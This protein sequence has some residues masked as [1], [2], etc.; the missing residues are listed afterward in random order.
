MELGHNRQTSTKIMGVAMNSMRKAAR[1]LAEHK[2]KLLGLL[3]AAA[4]PSAHSV[5]WNIDNYDDRDP[6]A[7]VDISWD[8][9][10]YQEKRYLR[11]YVAQNHPNTQAGVFAKA[12]VTADQDERKRLYQQCVERYPLH[13]KCVANGGNA[14]QRLHFIKNAKPGKHHY[15]VSNYLSDVSK[16]MSLPEKL[17]LV[18]KFEAKYGAQPATHY[19]RAEQYADENQHNKAGAE[20]NKSLSY[21]QS[22]FFHY[23]KAAN[24]K[25]K[26]LSGNGLREKAQ[27]LKSVIG[28]YANNKGLDAQVY[29][30]YGDKLESISGK[31]S[32]STD[33][34]L[35][36]WQLKPSAELAERLIRSSMDKSGAYTA[37]FKQMQELQQKIP[38]LSSEMVT[39]YANKRQPQKAKQAA[40]MAMANCVNG[41]DCQSVVGTILWANQNFINDNNWQA[42]IVNQLQRDY[43]NLNA[44]WKRKYEHERYL[45]R[46]QQAKQALQTYYKGLKNASDIWFEVKF[47]DLNRYLAAQ[48]KADSF[49]RD[50]PF[51]A[52]WQ[53]NFGESLK[54]QIEFATNSAVVPQRYYRE[55]DSMA[56]LMQR[57]DAQKYVFQLEGHTDSSGTNEHNQQLSQRRAAAVKQYLLK[58]HGIAAERIISKGYGESFPVASN[59]DELGKRKNRRVELLPYGRID[60]PK[61]QTNGRLNPKGTLSM[62]K[63]GEIIAIGSSPIELWNLRTKTKIHTLGRGNWKHKMSPNGRYL[64]AQSDWQN[65]DKSNSRELIVYDNKT[66]FEH[67]RLIP[68]SKIKKAVWSPSSDEIA[69]TSGA[70]TLSIYNL[71]A[72]KVDRSIVVDPRRPINNLA[73]DGLH[74]II[75]TAAA[76]QRH[77]EGFDAGSLASIGRMAGVNWVHRLELSP[78]QSRLLASDNQQQLHVFD[79]ADGKKLSS[80]RIGGGFADMTF[81]P[82][83][84]WVVFSYAGNNKPYPNDLFDYQSGQRLNSWKSENFGGYAFSPDGSKL[85]QARAETIV[86]ADSAELLSRSFDQA[87]TESWEN[88]VVDAQKILKVADKELMVVQNEKDLQVWDLAEAR[89]IHQWKKDVWL[90]QDDK[91]IW[92]FPQEG[93]K[94][95]AFKLNFD[96]FSVEQMFTLPVVPNR[97][98]ADQ[99]WLLIAEYGY[100]TD[101]VRTVAQDL[102][103]LRLLNSRTGQVIS[104]KDTTLV[105]GTR[106]YPRLYEAD[107]RAMAVS[108]KL[109]LI[110]YST[111]WQDGFGHKNKISKQITLLDARTMAVKRVIKR[112]SEIDKLEFRE[113]MLVSFENSRPHYLNVNN[114][115]LERTDWDES[116]SIK[117]VGEYQ[118]KKITTNNSNWIDFGN[119]DSRIFFKDNLRSVIYSAE[120]KL[121][122]ALLNSGELEYYR[123]GN[124]QKLLTLVASKNGEWLAFTPQGYYNSSNYG[125]EGSRWSFGDFSL[126]FSALANKYHNPKIIREQLAAAAAGND[127]R[128]SQLQAVDDVSDNLLL[129]PYKL[130]LPKNMPSSV[131]AKQITVPVTLAK[132]SA[133]SAAGVIEYSLNG[134]K[135]SAARGLGVVQKSSNGDCPTKAISCSQQQ[136]TFPLDAGRNILQFSVRYK[137]LNMDSQTL[138]VNRKVTAPLQAS[139]P[140]AANLWFFGV[141]VSEYQQSQYNLQYADAD[142][143]S[144]AKALK[145]QEGKLYRK[146][147][148]KVLTNA[149]VSEKKF[150]IELNRFL[151]QASSQ[152]TIIVFLAGHGSR[153]TDG[154]L[155]FMTHDSELELPY[156]GLN[157]SYVK[158]FLHKR[159]T[160]QK[161]LMWLDICHAGAIGSEWGK[162]RGRLSS[163][164]A[165]QM[166]IDGTG[167]AVMAS[168]TGMELSHEGKQYGGGHGAFTAALLEGLQGKADADAGDGNG[169]VSVM[170]LQSYVSSQ[171]P[172][173]TGGRQHPTSPSQI[174]LR[175]FPVSLH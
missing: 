16:D 25:V 115:K 22:Y 44:V 72:K 36:A 128:L 74:N 66:G 125:T 170:E 38:G 166:L 156:S 160:N 133:V 107:Y 29:R 171:V 162:T 49:Y 153:D 99:D 106:M 127:Q 147:H 119:Q 79:T 150:K 70:G 144:L 137:D 60:Q 158:D 27:V 143:E 103:K 100:D 102:G 134:Q 81:H 69:F 140:V 31:F 154:S 145:S 59:V 5:Q 58:Q 152:D 111:G 126:P 159:P 12:W 138:L 62:S 14:E 89:R 88:K 20:F 64:L 85:W 91:T 32:Y 120:L 8:T 75:Y 93:D 92:A 37:A 136:I 141:G 13:A 108:K 48:E 131:K 41:A 132:M 71:S 121:V 19:W 6:Q 110:A 46:Y 113:G 63:D 17:V 11:E 101:N 94:K 15:I 2:V 96:N 3:V 122:V 151:R 109:G 104:K 123:P 116:N 161:A 53:N 149:N 23:E 39:Y 76:T 21:P 30:F 47:N 175:D 84:P 118:G 73:W 87:L 67:S 112:D 52:Y 168:S 42:Q 55:L 117:T 124:A 105:T 90:M 40:D 139:S 164:D 68:G 148:T 43:P 61:L 157:V 146:V 173:I 56:K 10:S 78:D 33:A 77:I 26:H 163:D 82:Q 97:V 167:V 18:E 4:V 98:E 86:S 24:H 80:T 172:K 65:S 28:Q 165:V 83:K 54:V 129:L 35:Q 155:Y 51:L 130:I 57:R 50:N 114:G 34:W 169:M 9:S 142:A 1:Q 45:G 7:L 135:L 174:R 95:I